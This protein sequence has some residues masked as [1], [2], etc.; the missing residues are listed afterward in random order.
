MS[1]FQST[2]I[3]CSVTQVDPGT[4]PGI[5]LTQVIFQLRRFLSNE[6]IKIPSCLRIIDH[7]LTQQLVAVGTVGKWV[8]H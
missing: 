4:N 2:L 3:Y 8:L 1:W 5:S 6:A 7:L